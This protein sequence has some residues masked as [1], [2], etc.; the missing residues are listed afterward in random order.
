[1]SASAAAGKRAVIGKRMPSTAVCQPLM[2][3][4]GNSLVALWTFSIVI[5]FVF[6]GTILL[7]HNQDAFL[8]LFY[9]MA[10]R[11]GVNSALSIP[12]PVNK[13]KIQP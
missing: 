5:I 11:H 9:L 3:I 2:L 6:K 13:K 12:I 8:P 7:W 1:M 4:L 10:N